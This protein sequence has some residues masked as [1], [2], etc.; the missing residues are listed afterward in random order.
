MK[1]TRGAL[2]GSGTKLSLE[3]KQ[4]QT[5]TYALNPCRVMACSSK[6]SG[7]VKATKM[8]GNVN[9]WESHTLREQRRST[10]ANTNRSQMEL[11]HKD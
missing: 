8:F 4:K 6:G 10:D 3:Q 2:E 11:I 1:W 7:G 5:G 9:N